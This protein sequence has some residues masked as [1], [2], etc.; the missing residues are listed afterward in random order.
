MYIVFLARVHQGT[1]K[2]DLS[3]RLSLVDPEAAKRKS[4]KRKRKRETEKEELG[5]DGENKQ[6]IEE[7]GRV[8]VL[9]SFF[10]C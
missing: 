3:L 1:G 10:Q 2:V 9:L 6:E 4:D 7:H 8:L 5:S